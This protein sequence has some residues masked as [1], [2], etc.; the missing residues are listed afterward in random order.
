MKNKIFS[1][2]IFLALSSIITKL[3]GAI[4]RIPLTNTLGLEGL[5]IY[6]MVFPVYCLMLDFSGQGLPF[7]LSKIISS[8]LTEKE[9]KLKMLRVAIKTFIKI[10]GLLTLV[11]ML[12]SYPL[13]TL[14]GNKNAY[15]SYIFLAPAIL[16]VS[17]ISCFRGYFQ[18]NLN[19]FPTASSQVIEQVIKIVLGLLLTSLFLPSITLSAGG[20]TLAVSIS[21]LIAL[22][23]LIKVFPK[24]EKNKL[25]KL[26][27][28]KFEERNINKQIFRLI[29]P[30]T[31]SG[32]LLPF[33]QIVDSFIIVN[34][35]NKNGFLGTSLYGLLSGSATTIINF[36]VSVC[37]AV[38]VVCVPLISRAKDRQ[39]K[40][41]NTNTAL[42]VTLVI[43]FCGMI[44]CRIFAQ[45][46]V[47][48]LFK[49]FS[50]SQKQ[51]A[52]NLIKIMSFAIVF[53]SLVQTQNSILVANGKT[54]A[55]LFSMGIGIFLKFI[56]EIVLVQNKRFNILGGGIAVITCYFVT[57]LI[58]LFIITIIKARNE[59]KTPC[60]KQCTT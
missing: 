28:D 47:D 26:K 6:Q 37:Y 9:D 13:S 18:G 35:L 10:G 5:G 29:I 45:N 17:I 30:I 51:T 24:E 41:K 55:P 34:L 40:T 38:S 48:V 56:L 4:Y 3:L 27:I 22:L 54:F 19:M 60:I 58:N 52:I 16:F 25:F 23:F 11:L 12:V 44:F 36:P 33:S 2:A 1:G 53:L 46:I 43:S 31:I 7:A 50:L 39:S 42:L 21:E 20:A 14:Q 57:C 8:N 59:N 32:C 49:S 15:L